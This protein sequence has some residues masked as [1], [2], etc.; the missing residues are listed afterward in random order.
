M[1][2]LILAVTLALAWQQATA[3]LAAQGM[4]GSGPTDP[5]CALVTEQEVEAV[6]GLDYRP[7]Y[8]IEQEYELLE[9]G[10]TCM[11]GGPSMAYED[12][13]EITITFFAAGARESHTEWR[14]KKRLWSGCSREPAPD[15]GDGAF[16]EICEGKLYSVKVY[17]RSGNNDVLVSV[18]QL[19]PMPKASVKAAAIALAKTAAARAKGL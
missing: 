1:H 8:D 14:R 12:L 10:A 11:W 9:G 4:Q 3:E 15:V 5:G 17:S 13:P 19:A 16:A 6:T 2:P 7:G 18:H